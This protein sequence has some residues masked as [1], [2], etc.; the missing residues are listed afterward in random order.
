MYPEQADGCGIREVTNCRGLRLQNWLDMLHSTNLENSAVELE[1]SAVHKVFKLQ[2]LLISHSTCNKQKSFQVCIAWEN[3]QITNKFWEAETRIKLPACS[4][5]RTQKTSHWLP[6]AQA[7]VWI[8]AHWENS[9]KMGVPP[10]WLTKIQQCGSEAGLEPG[11]WNSLRIRKI[12]LYAA[13]HMQWCS[14]TQ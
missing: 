2:L 8:A 4:R 10:Y 3:F 7:I 11:A 9:E 6:T 5:E 1:R 12:Q 14:V 13:A